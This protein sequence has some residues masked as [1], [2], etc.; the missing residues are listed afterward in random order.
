MNV[1]ILGLG[2]IA[3]TMADT[4]SHLGIYGINL[5]AVASRS[6]ERAESFRKQHGAKIAYGSY[7]ELLKDRKVDLVYIAT[8]HAI[9]YQNCMACIDARKPVL[10]EKPFTTDALKAQR[11]FAQA[12]KN[13]VFITEAM[14]TRYMPSRKVINSL[15]ESKLIGELVSI[16]VDL[17]YSIEDK[18][19]MVDPK[20]GGGALLDVGVYPLTFACMVT[21]SHPH[22]FHAQC[23]YTENRLDETDVFVLNFDKGVTATCTCSMSSLSDRRG[24]IQ[25][26][27]GFI[28]V[29]NI[30]NPLLIKV[31]NQNLQLIKTEEI[32]EKF[33]GYEYELFEC[34]KCLE[35]KKLECS[36]LPH[37]ET[38]KMLKLTDA[39]RERLGIVYPFDENITKKYLFQ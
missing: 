37:E 33:S 4:I 28:E 26:T 5:Y 12:K 17:S 15:I 23:T 10:C 25:G 20:L 7:E 9:H 32:V 2:R 3:T 30:N 29:D 21:N 38:I 14:W 35:E 18:S 31:Y 36:S 16:R 22:S 24:I 13:K 27:K 34:A 6:F 1:G 11:I 8:P 19:R 39:I